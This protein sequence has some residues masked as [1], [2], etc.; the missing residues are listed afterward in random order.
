MENKM[1]DQLPIREWSFA[2]VFALSSVAALVCAVMATYWT[3]EEE[4]PHLWRFVLICGVMAGLMGIA[5]ALRAHYGKDTL[6]GSLFLGLSAAVLMMFIS[7]THPHRGSMDSIVPDVIAITL[8][9]SIGVVI[10]VFIMAAQKK[11]IVDG[12]LIWAG[13]H[14]AKALLSV[15]AGCSMGFAFF[16]AVDKLYPDFNGFAFLVGLMLG[17]GLYSLVWVYLYEKRNGIR[18]IIER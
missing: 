1:Q 17:G 10:G 9:F 13:S 18:I 7:T 4:L 3:F 6:R 8:G 15:I 5:F 12:R 2:K 16:Y 14:A 11:R